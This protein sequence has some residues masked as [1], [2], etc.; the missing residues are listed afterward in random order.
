MLRTFLS[1][2]RANNFLAKVQYSVLAIAHLFLTKNQCSHLPIAL[3][4]FLN[5]IICNHG[6]PHRGGWVVR[7][8][9]VFKHSSKKLGIFGPS[10]LLAGAS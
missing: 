8:G 5:K 4:V 7:D 3:A 6:E 1:L 2:E 9:A 10:F